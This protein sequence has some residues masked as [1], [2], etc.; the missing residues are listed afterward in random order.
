MAMYPQLMWARSR[1]NQSAIEKSNTNLDWKENIGNSRIQYEDTRIQFRQ[2]L[3]ILYNTVINWKYLLRTWVTELKMGKCEETT[4]KN[5][6]IMK[7][8]KREL[9]IFTPNT[10]K[11]KGFIAL[12]FINALIFYYY[13]YFLVIAAAQL[14]EKAFTRITWA[15]FSTARI[16]KSW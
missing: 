14:D 10:D 7:K 15:E 1:Q 13:Y 12:K 4:T 5:Q 16:I 11:V 8:E 3:C 6:T 9:F 2:T